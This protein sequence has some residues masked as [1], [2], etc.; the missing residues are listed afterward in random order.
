VKFHQEKKKAYVCP[1]GGTCF[2][3]PQ[4]GKCITPFPGKLAFNFLVCLKQKKKKTFKTSPS[5]HLLH[6]IQVPIRS[7]NKR[8]SGQETRKKPFLTGSA[9]ALDKSGKLNTEGQPQ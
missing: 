3:T 5:K 6:R 8:P 2:T 1:V 7:E 9:S 4:K